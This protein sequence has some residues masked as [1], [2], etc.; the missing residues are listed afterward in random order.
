M[1]LHELKCNLLGVLK[2]YYTL[3]HYREVI[4]SNYRGSKSYHYIE[5][6]IERSNRNINFIVDYYNLRVV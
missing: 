2:N 4:E 5:E 1:S 6:V 3:I